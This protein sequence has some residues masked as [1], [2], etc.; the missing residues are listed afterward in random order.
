MHWMIHIMHIILLQDLKREMKKNFI[1]MKHSTL[2][3]RQQPLSIAA[4]L[5]FVSPQCASRHNRIVVKSIK[6]KFHD[7]LISSEFPGK[8]GQIPKLDRECMLNPAPPP[9]VIEPFE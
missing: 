8:S 4:T 2:D 7:F 5:G 6:S 9:R 3:E 1:M